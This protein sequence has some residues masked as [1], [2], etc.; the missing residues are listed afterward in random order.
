MKHV[1]PCLLLVA[2]GGRVDASTTGHVEPEPLP[3]V[4]ADAAPEPEASSPEPPRVLGCIYDSERLSTWT[5]GDDALCSEMPGRAAYDN[6]AGTTC[7]V[8]MP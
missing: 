6:G 7:C 1:F 5:R 3:V 8:V 2:C 4:I